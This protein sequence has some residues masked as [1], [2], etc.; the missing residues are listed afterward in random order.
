[1]FIRNRLKRD[2]S[3]DS[4]LNSRNVKKTKIK[5]SNSSIDI[6]SSKKYLQTSLLL[7]NYQ[8]SIYDNFRMNKASSIENSERGIR[9]L[10]QEI[11]QKKIDDKSSI[12][13]FYS[14]VSSIIFCN[15]RTERIKVWFILF[16]V[17]PLQ[18]TVF[19]QPR[20]SSLFTAP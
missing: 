17:L 8:E 18:A 14:C 6:S 16:L 9:K 12:L 5:K 4:F 7:N 15:L 11:K 3:I 19:L 1:M 13:V 20:L 10:S 2:N